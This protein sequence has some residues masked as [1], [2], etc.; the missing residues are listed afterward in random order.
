MR[1]A[2][3]SGSGRISGRTSSARSASTCS[4]CSSASSASFCFIRLST[5]LMRSP[6]VPWWPGS[7]V[8]EGGTHVHHMVFGIIIMMA[9]ACLSFA[10]SNEGPWYSIWAVLFGIGMGLTIDEYALWLHLD[11]VYWSEEGRSSIDAALDSG[12]LMALGLVAAVPVRITD[13]NRLEFLASIVLTAGACGLG[14]RVLRQAAAG[15]RHGRASSSPRSR[16]MAPCGSA[17]RTRPGRAVSTASAIR[18]S[19]RGPSSA[20]IPGVRTEVIKNRVLDAHRRRA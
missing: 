20:S 6:R 7:V 15:A 1:D 5:R 9:A 14:A 17:S 2:W 13:E 16:S 10:V 3:R 4:W 11:D 18:R 8:T 19:R 12:G